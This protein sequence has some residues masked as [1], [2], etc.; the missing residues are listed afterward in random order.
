MKRTRTPIAE[1]AYEFGGR[2]FR[3]KASPKVVAAARRAFK[4]VHGREGDE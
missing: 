4:R 3:L 2:F 1:F